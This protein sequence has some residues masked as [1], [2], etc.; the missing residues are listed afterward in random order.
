MLFCS[1]FRYIEM[2]FLKNE[3]FVSKNEEYICI[4]LNIIS[5]KQFI[6]L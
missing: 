3:L 1:L 5:E 4:L 2:F 6:S